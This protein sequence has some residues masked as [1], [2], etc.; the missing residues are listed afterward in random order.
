[1]TQATHAG[2]ERTERLRRVFERAVEAANWVVGLTLT[3]G[4]LAFAIRWNV[5]YGG[6]GSIRQFYLLTAW[7]VGALELVA[8]AA[9]LRRSALRWVLQMIPMIVPIVAYQWFVLKFIFRTL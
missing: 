5:R 3:L 6:F 8:A 9:M 7:S 2:L 1:M 4:A